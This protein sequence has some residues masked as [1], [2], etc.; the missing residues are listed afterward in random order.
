MASMT[1]LRL[2]SV[3]T[4]GLGLV[5]LMVA[6][7]ESVAC[8]QQE[9]ATRQTAAGEVH[10]GAPPA[11]KATRLIAVEGFDHPDGIAY[12]SGSDRFFV[13]NSGVALG[14][15]P[16]RGFIS[17]VT[18][19]GG[20]DSLHFVAAY[21]GGPLRAPTGLRVRRDTLWVLDVD[22]LHAFDTHTGTHLRSIAFADLKP[23]RVNDFDWGPDG[24]FYITDVGTGS[25]PAGN[26]PLGTQMRILR[27]TP[28]GSA[29]VALAN[30]I[31]AAPS[32]IAWDPLESRFLIA[33]SS[34]PSMLEWRIGQSVVESIVSSPPKLDG[35]CDGVEVG[36]DGRVLVTN[37]GTGS[38]YQLLN[39]RL[40]AWVTG[41]DTP[42]DVAV[43]TRR[44]RL[45]VCEFDAN[46]VSIWTLSEGA[47]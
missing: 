2:L 25:T 19:D 42:A 10:G 46:R 32:G 21:A 43:D 45:A 5:V 17:R 24:A 8:R 36:Q 33:P 3:R 4:S 23:R 7:V 27:V 6:S 18:S 44:G 13:S 12:D 15:D 37:R 47:S 39:G 26:P 22:A 29:S 34:G 20:I 28:G 35:G 30:P 40:V 1:P 9:Q 16:R 41:L 38:V 14:A 31:L 11:A